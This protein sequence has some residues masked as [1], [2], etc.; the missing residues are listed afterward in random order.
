DFY[1]GQVGGMAEINL[2]SLFVQTT[3]KVALGT[4]HQGTSISGSTTTNDLSGFTV[5]QTF[6][7]GYLGVP[8]NSGRFS[9]DRF[10]VVPEANL[11]VG[12]QPTTGVRLFA[13]YTFLYLSDVARPGDQVDRVIAPGQSVAFFAMP[14]RSVPVQRPTFLGRDND[15]FAHG[16]NFGL[17]FAY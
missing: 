7:G 11:S 1:G 6:P 9:R 5:V 15:F 4:V 3:A 14:P 13:G 8:S 2:G 17:E 16:L 12:W 10:C